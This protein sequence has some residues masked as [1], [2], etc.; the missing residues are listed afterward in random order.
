[1]TRWEGTP[2]SNPGY[3]LEVNFERLPRR[4]VYCPHCL[5][6]VASLRENFEDHRPELD[7]N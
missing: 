6:V 3:L 5:A 1:M 2:S 7:D 4:Y